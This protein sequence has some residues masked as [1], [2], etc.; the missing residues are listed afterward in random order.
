[1]NAAT[2]GIY[3]FLIF[4]TIKLF[5]MSQAE[6]DLQDAMDK[7]QSSV[8]TMQEQVKTA[9][10]TL[11]DEVANGISEEG[12]QKAIGQLKAIQA[13]VESTTTSD[14][15]TTDTPPTIPPA[16]PAAEA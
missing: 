12:V 3:L 14:A 9:I 16:A 7:L 5:K 11:E 6:Q 10:K 1:M 2:F 8:D 4:I 15:P 13:D